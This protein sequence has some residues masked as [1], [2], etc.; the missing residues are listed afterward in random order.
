MVARSFTL[1]AVAALLLLVAFYGLGLSI[2]LTL[3]AA[4]VYLGTTGRDAEARMKGLLA[5][6]VA[7]VAVLWSLVPRL[8]RFVPPGPALTEGDQPRLFGLIK[9]VANEMGQ[10]M[11]RQVYLFPEANAFVASVGGFLGLGSR[12]VLGVGLGLLAVEN[13]SQVKATLAHEFGHFA[14]GDTRLGGLTYGMRN[15]MIR[16]VEQLERQN[17]VVAAPF[18]WI[19]RLYLRITQAISRQQE[20]LADEWSVRIA[21]KTAHVSGLRQEA[22]HAESFGLFLRHEVHPLAGDGVAP[23]N[24][25]EAFR[26]FSASSRYKQL[27]P[28]LLKLIAERPG[29]PFDSHPALAERI[30]WAHSLRASDLPVDHTPGISLL[31][32]AE[33]YETQFSRQLAGPALKAVE[34]SEIGAAM[35]PRLE[36]TAA[37]VQVRVE[38]MNVQ[39][40]LDVLR[41][42][43]R[44]DAFVQ[45]VDPALIEW[46]TPDRAQHLEGNLASALEAYL[47]VLLAARGFS[48]E[49]SPGEPLR[50]VRDGVVVSLGALI[51]DVLQGRKP[52][53]AV[54]KPLDEAGLPRLATIEVNEALREL[55]AAP[56]CEI[57]LE[58]KRKTVVVSAQRET[59]MLPRCCGVCRGTVSELVPMRFGV[60]TSGGHQ[61]IELLEVPL[62]AQHRR[63]PKK[64]LTIRSWRPMV[65]EVRFEVN[66]PAYAELIC[67]VNA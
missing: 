64:V 15:A 47:G 8:G 61:M 34:W 27:E 10:P 41:N 43:P 59:L 12:R 28:A 6:S 38:G 58:Q 19:S 17:S 29:A 53:D 1:R 20:L 9:Q 45:A 62:C 54:A 44:R 21:G 56:R 3:L 67:A 37:R 11:P 57:K 65:G 33:A 14:R 4:A 50:L 13:V 48:W 39:L 2:G 60:D 5:L 31:D 32:G 16:S 40:G 63:D 42:Q 35:A 24:L 25:Y 52:I 51:L 66:D 18:R 7:G 23:K 55:L 36:R 30:A 26:K 46:N 49:S 22:V